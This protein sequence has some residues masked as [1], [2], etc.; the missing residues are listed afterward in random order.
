MPIRSV[1]DVLPRFLGNTN[2]LRL[3]FWL[4]LKSTHLYPDALHFATRDMITHPH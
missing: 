2:K 1:S 4:M 3:W